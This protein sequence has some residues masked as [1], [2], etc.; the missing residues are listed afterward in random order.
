[1]AGPRRS[2]GRSS[3]IRHP[4]LQRQGMDVYSTAPISLSP[5]LEPIHGTATCAGFAAT[6]RTEPDYGRRRTA[7]RRYA[8]AR[9]SRAPAP[10]HPPRSLALDALERH[11]IRKSSNTPKG[12]KPKPPA[13]WASASRHSTASWKVTASSRHRTV[14]IPRRA[15]YHFDRTPFFRRIAKERKRLFQSGLNKRRFFLAPP[16]YR[17]RHEPNGGCEMQVILMI[18]F[19]AASD[20][21]SI[22]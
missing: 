19:F 2:S 7:L 13:C 17:S 4:I 5:A 3:S 9:K 18:L 15:S 10:A 20:A 8:V 1:M 12:T 22:A 6:R 14:F 16:S 21:C 11:H